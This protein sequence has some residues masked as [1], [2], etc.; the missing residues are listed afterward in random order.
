MRRPRASPRAPSRCA[1]GGEDA[2]DVGARAAE[3]RARLLPGLDRR[4]ARIG[5]GRQPAADAHAHAPDDTPRRGR[6]RPSVL[7]IFGPTGVGKTALALALAE[8][9]RAP[10]RAAGRRLG[11]RAAGLPRPRD[12]HRRRRPPPSR[13]A[14]STG[15]SR[16]CPSTRA[17]GRRVRRARARRDR[18][19]ARAAGARPIVV[20]GTGLYLRAALA[21]PRR[22]ARRRPTRSARAGRTSS[23][24]AAP[25]RCT[26]SSRARAPW[27]AER[28]R[29]RATAAGS[30]ARSSC[31]SSAS[32]SRP[33]G[34]NQLWTADTRHPD[35]PGRARHG[36]RGALRA[37]RRA[38]RRDGRRRRRRGGPRRP[39]RR[40]PRRPR[41]RRWA[42]T[43]CWPATSR[44]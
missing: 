19:A 8:R 3:R 4:D 23:S 22:C 41:A 36:P 24:A 35:A 2:D 42:S 25:R 37:D 10:R 5:A 9:L 44:R 20:G 1:A 16:S 30:S 17:S 40:A 31:S 18:R 21:R 32:S 29:A 13:R 28:D 27:A 11:R 7:A 12:A 26:P 14:S 6:I 15:S 39:R 34:P 43:S 38:R 33:R